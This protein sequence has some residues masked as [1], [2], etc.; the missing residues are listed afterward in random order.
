L[1]RNGL[2]P[3]LEEL[4]ASTEQL[5]NVSC[6]LE[7]DRTVTT[8]DPAVTINV[9]RIVQEAIT[10]AI[11]HGGARN[12]TIRLTTENGR[13]EL[14]VESDGLA[15]SDRQAD[16]IRSPSGRRA[17]QANGSGMGLRIMRYRAE[18]INGSLDV[19][20]GAHG[21]TCVTCVFPNEGEPRA[22]APARVFRRKDAR[23]SRGGRR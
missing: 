13:A 14:S 9:Y 18:T 4:A 23:L 10:N 8:R 17:G 15:F 12:V 21:G 11:K 19:R 6:T 1:D 20:K 16:R 2:L 7:C 22:S 5:F 3:A